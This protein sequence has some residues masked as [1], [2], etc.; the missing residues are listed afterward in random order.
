MDLFNLSPIIWGMGSWD[1]FFLIKHSESTTLCFFSFIFY[2]FCT[3]NRDTHSCLPSWCPCEFSWF[4][5][6]VCFIYCKDAKVRRKVE[7]SC[8]TTIRMLTLF[9]I[10]ICLLVWREG[11]RA[12]KRCGCLLVLFLLPSPLLSYNI[13][14]PDGPLMGL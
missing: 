14:S 10:L 6:H 9:Y 7:E 4:Y 1:D 3:P 11:L 13:A 12:P 5:V 8:S 2:S